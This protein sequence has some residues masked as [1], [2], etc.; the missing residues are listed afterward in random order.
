M[1]AEHNNKEVGMPRKPRMYMEGYPCHVIQRGNNRSRCFFSDRD[2]H[3]YLNF[4]SVACQR[5]SVALHAY[6]LMTNHAH[7]LMTPTCKEGI[8]RVMQ[9]LGR[10]YVQYINQQFRW[11]GT[12]WEG[13]HKASLVDA[14]EYLLACYRYIEMNPVRAAM[15]EH[16]GDYPW[17]S[18]HA[19]AYGKIDKHLQPHSLYL[20]LGRHSHGRQLAYRELFTGALDQKIVHVIRNAAN[21]S[22]PLGNDRFAKQIEETLGR[23]LGFA[24]TGR[25]TVL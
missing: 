19:N 9:S 24:K 20:D 23:K 17:S 25:P 10:R 11:S 16:P 3:T 21:F 15:V 8:S 14:D 13:R 1:A 4:L 18:Y 12:L 6:I 22:M 2:Y 5:Y 7:L